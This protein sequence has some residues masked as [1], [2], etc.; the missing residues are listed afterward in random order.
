MSKE[1]F[2]D[3]SKHYIGNTPLKEVLKKLPKE[4]VIFSFSQRNKI[5]I[6]KNLLHEIG[7]TQVDTGV[8]HTFDTDLLGL[9]FKKKQKDQQEL[10]FAIKYFYHAFMGHGNIDLN[11]MYDRKIYHALKE[12]DINNGI[13]PVEL[14]TH[15]QLYEKMRA[16]EIIPYTTIFFFDQ[17]RWYDTHMK[18]E[19][20]PFDLHSLL[21]ITD[22]LIYRDKLLHPSKTSPWE[23][24]H[25]KL[26]IFI[27]VR[28]TEIAGL[29]KDVSNSTVEVDNMLEN[30]Y[31]YKC[32]LLL[33][34]MSE[35][36]NSLEKNVESEDYRVFIEKRNRFIHI[37]SNSCG[38]ATK[39]Q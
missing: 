29:L 15:E 27:G 34:Q 22:S 17:D 35:T 16:Q 7:L 25:T 5:H 36:F 2:T 3:K 23:A 32:K 6:A 33:N 18:R 21:Q 39:L 20:K 4:N 10:Y 24:I 13:K 30:T 8:H 28:Q 26:V 38:I 37:I 9:F 14:L 12:N 11:N 31:F 1:S 19:Q